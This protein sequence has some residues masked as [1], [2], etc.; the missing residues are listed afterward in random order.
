MLEKLKRI[1]YA[2]AIAGM[3][4]G[5]VAVV[6]LALTPH[7]VIGPGRFGAFVHRVEGFDFKWWLTGTA[8]ALWLFPIL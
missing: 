6:V 1:I 8:F 3:C 4:L 7:L 5:F 2:I